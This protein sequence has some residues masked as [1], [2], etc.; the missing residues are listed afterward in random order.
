MSIAV[1][2]QVKLTT[3]QS[4]VR[5]SGLWSTKPQVINDKRKAANG[6]GGNTSPTPFDEVATGKFGTLFHSASTPMAAGFAS[7][8]KQSEMML[9]S[10]SVKFGIKSKDLLKLLQALFGH[11][12][13]SMS[14]FKDYLTKCALNGD[15]HQMKDMLSLLGDTVT[16]H[17]GDVHAAAAELTDLRLQKTQQDKEERDA[18]EEPKHRR[19]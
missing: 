7:L 2:P 15:T 12:F 18:L 9:K 14:H 6:Q 19:R 17:K 10:L 1:K 4:L 11:S 5:H 3:A 13:S 16:K 8:F